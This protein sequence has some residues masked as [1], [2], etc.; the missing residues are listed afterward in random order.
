MYDVAVIAV[1]LAC[2]AFA[3]LLIYLYERI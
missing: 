3:F 1:F 2:F